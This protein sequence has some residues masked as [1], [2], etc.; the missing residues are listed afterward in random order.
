MNVIKAIQTIYPNIQGGFSY[1]QT[2][3][4]GSDWKNPIEGLVWENKQFEKPTWEQIEAANQQLEEDLKET[5]EKK[6]LRIKSELI[7]SRKSFLEFSRVEA[8][9]S[10]LESQ[11]YPEKEKR[12]RA[13]QEIADIQSSNTLT[14]LNKFSQDF[15]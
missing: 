2:K 9:E 4:D 6:K 7:S 11:D 12:Q 15:E 13:K 3:F 5:T 10:M 1:W 14:A 8:I